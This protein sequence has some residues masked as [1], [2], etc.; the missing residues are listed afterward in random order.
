MGK[1]Q[2]PHITITGRGRASAPAEITIV[3]LHLRSLHK[4][5]ATV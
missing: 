1:H 5:Q 4:D 2:K 3:K